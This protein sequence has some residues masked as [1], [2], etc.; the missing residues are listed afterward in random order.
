MYIWCLY[1]KVKRD[2][3]TLYEQFK[4]IVNFTDHVDI[5]GTTENIKK[6]IIFKGPNVWILAFATIIA[7]VGLN[8]NSVPVIIGAMLVSPLMGPIMGT[9]LAIGINDS[10]LLRK[11]LKNLSIMVLISILA[12]TA[13]F[14]VSPLALAEPTEL[15]ARTRPT[16]Y[17]VFIAFFGGLAGIVE[18]SRKEKGTVIA[19]V[20]IATALMPPLCTAGYGLA[21][22]NISYFGGAI[23]LFTI[24]SLFIA[25]STF[26]IIRYLKFPFV[27][28]ADP[29]KQRRVRRTISLFTLLMIIPSIYTGFIVIRE[30][31]FN[32]S[33]KRF[34]S[35]NKSLENGYIYDYK[36]NHKVKPSLLEISVAGEKMSE[37][38]KEFLLQRV[39]MYGI[40]RS[41]V[42][43]KENAYIDAGEREQNVV[44]SIFERSDIEIGKR[45]EQIKELELKLDSVLSLKIPYAQITEEMLAQHPGIVSLSLARG[46][47]ISTAPFSSK[48][49]IV[50]LIKWREPLSDEAVLKLQKWLSVRLKVENVKIEQVR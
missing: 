46:A 6:S 27:Q 4:S 39:E 18:S 35:E 5:E 11:A 26:I 42:V 28:F 32:Q 40:F 45:E 30:N 24:N 34:I 21:N 22:G 50:A 7:S 15:L 47:E 41:Q 44:K 14:L 37:R 16:I 9:G 48:D 38:Q 3:P 31:S 29:A 13:Y 19:G 10:Q 17:D 8:V 23:Y 2:M 33:V 36:I 43:I 49:Q 25:L 12:S 20:A 1:L